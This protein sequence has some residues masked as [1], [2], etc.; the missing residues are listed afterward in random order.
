MIGDAGE[1]DTTGATLRDLKIKLLNNPNSCVIFLGDNCYKQI[2]GG[3]AKAERKGFDGKKITRK[4]M[5]SQLNILKDHKGSAYFIPGNHDWWNGISVKKGKKNLLKEEL[6]VNEEVKKYEGLLNRNNGAFFPKSGEAGPV[7]IELNEGKI[8][9]IFIDTYR[10]I[11]EAIKG[12]PKNKLY[13]NRFYSDL[14]EELKNAQSKD[15]KI[16]IAGHHPILS[17]GNHSGKIKFFHKYI[18]RFA[19]SNTNYKPNKSI[20]FGIDSLMKKYD[21]SGIYYVGGHE[22]SL[23]YFYNDNRRYIISGA[24]SKVDKVKFENV[25]TKDEFL[26]WNEEGFFEIDFYPLSEKIIL[27]HR[28]NIRSELQSTCVDGC[29]N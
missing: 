8:R 28:K 3:L 7:A 29:N 25:E 23:E 13:L 4:R 1:N 17:K 2:L 12:K 20:A 16:I 18:K 15:Q 14:E 24:G 9:M 5:L 22:H 6:F 21:R 11:L 10:L 27:H 26:K 19:N